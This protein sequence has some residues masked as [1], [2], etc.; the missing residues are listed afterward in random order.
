MIRT[1]L[2][3]MTGEYIEDTNI[4][5]SIVTEVSDPKKPIKKKK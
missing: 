2:E 5:E 1:A 4:D 3:I